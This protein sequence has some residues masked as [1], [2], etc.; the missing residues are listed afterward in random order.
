M[1]ESFIVSTSVVALAEVGD[2]TQLL[3]LILAARYKKPVPIIFGTLIATLLNHA[4]AGG[5]GT[6]L[7]GSLSPNIINW[8]VV[9]SFALM[10][11]W[12]LI[13]DKL[14]GDEL[15]TVKKTT[16]IFATTVIVFFLAEMGDKTQ[17]VT[18]ALA[19]HFRDFLGVVS[20][21][22]TGMMIANIPVIFLGHQFSDKL[23]IKT[24]HFIA[25]AI[26]LALGGLALKN[27]L[28]GTPLSF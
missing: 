12:I 13:P 17:V 11:V 3:S 27:A 4:A 25:S 2:K 8:A 22:T 6:W 21:T 15:Q 28:T 24:V 7:S 14:D 23:P 18:I 26:F 16:G 9:V 1:M 20:G 19:A 10:A 5:L